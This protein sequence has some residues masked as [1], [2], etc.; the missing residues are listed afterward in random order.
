MYA[1]QAIYLR[2]RNKI[3][4]ALDAEAVSNLPDEKLREQLRQAV[5]ALI[6]REAI[7]APVML[8]QEFVNRFIDEIKGLG[9]LQPLV[10]DPEVSDI[11]VNGPDCVY[12]EKRGLLTK[13]DVTFIDES[14]L[15]SIAKRIAATVGRRVDESQPMCD[16]RLEDGSRVNI[17]IPPIALDGTTISIRKF[18]RMDIG[19][20]RMVDFGSLSQEMVGLLRSR[21]RL[22]S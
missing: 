20:S 13:T 16:A 19:L 4:N 18:S 6:E 3:F 17:A 12:V 5:D 10:M 21:L 7:T 11:M 1:P 9:P 8:R 15:L 2:L 14:Q 22:P